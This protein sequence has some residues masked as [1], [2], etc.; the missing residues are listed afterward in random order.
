MYW[1][2]E[3]MVPA[4][5]FASPPE[6]V[7]VT[8]AAPP[9]FSVAENCSTAVP[10]EFVVL[11]PVQFVSRVAVPGEIENSLL[12]EPPEAVEPP[13]PARMNSAGNMAIATMRAGQ[14]RNIG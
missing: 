9:A 8:L 11:Q 6:T 4:P 13:Q 7:Q 14:C 10:E 1:P 12:E 2:L 5:E 3:L